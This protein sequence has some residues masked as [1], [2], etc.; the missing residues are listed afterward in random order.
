MAMID[1]YA[2]LAGADVARFLGRADDEALAQLA[3]MHIAQVSALCRSYTRGAGFMMTIENDVVSARPND[4]IAAVII[5][6]T[7]RLVTNPAQVQS[8]EA[9]GYRTSGSFQGFTLPERAVLDRYRRRA[10]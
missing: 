5:L 7:A 3:G 9:D 4:E 6:A 10:G 1:R 8:E 2:D